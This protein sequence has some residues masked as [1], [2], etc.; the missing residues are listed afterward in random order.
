MFAIGDLSLSVTHDDD[1]SLKIKGVALL[2]RAARLSSRYSAMAA[3]NSSPRESLLEAFQW[4][5]K[6]LEAG[7]NMFISTLT[8]RIDIARSRGGMTLVS[9]YTL[10]TA[11]GALM[12]L[13][14]NAYCNPSS[15]G[16]MVYAAMTVADIAHELEAVDTA[17]LGSGVGVG[18]RDFVYCIVRLVS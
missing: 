10:T 16:K 7:I 11:H 1:F 4:D 5:L 8:P 6:K 9:L 15:Y 2:D 13:Y 18:V 17:F 14:G 12:E 3:S